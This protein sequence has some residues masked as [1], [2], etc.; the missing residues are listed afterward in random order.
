MERQFKDTVA[1]RR[2][3]ERTLQ[4]AHAVLVR[5]KSISY[6]AQ[7][8]YTSCQWVHKSMETMPDAFL[9]RENIPPCWAR[10]PP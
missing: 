8:T 4:I 2:F 6:V 7:A 3:T 1:G 9:E 10:K 5:G